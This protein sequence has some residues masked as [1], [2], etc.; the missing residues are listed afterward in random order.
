MTFP[1]TNP[2]PR[3]G[4]T[5]GEFGLLAWLENTC[6]VLPLKVIDVTFDVAGDLA[7]VG[8]DQVFHQTARKPLDILYTFPLPDGAAVF[9]CEVIINDRVLQARVEK[10]ERAREIA[11]AM[12]QAGHRTDFVE[13]DRKNLFTLSLGNVQPDDLIV[14]RLAWFQVLD[15]LQNSKSLRIPFTPGVRYIPGKPLLRSNQ[16]KGTLDD[17]DQVPEASRVLPPRINELHPDAAVISLRGMLDARFL[18]KQSLSSA[19]H[20]VLVRDQDDGV[21]VSLS[22]EGHVPDRDFVLRWE[23]RP[24]EALEFRSIRC[25]DEQHQYAVLGLDAA[26]SA[27]VKSHENNDYYFLVDRSRSMAGRKWACTAQALQAFIAELDEAERVW[28]TLFA[29]AHQEYAEAPLRVSELREDPAFPALVDLGVGGGTE[30]LPAL[31][32]VLLQIATHSTEKKAVVILI[33]DGQ[34]GNEQEIARVLSH[35]PDLRL[36]TFGIDTAV[37]G[38]FLTGLASEHRGTC[39]L[40]KP[41]DDIR[42]AITRLGT[43]L[44]RPLLTDLILPN[45]W[46]STAGRLPDIHAGEHATVALRGPLGATSLE[47]TGTVEDKLLRAYS[48]SLK[49]GARSA[50]RLLW[51]RETIDHLLLAKKYDEAIEIAM[52]HNIICPGTAFIAY[53][54][55]QKV[56]F[57]AQEIYQPAQDTAQQRMAACAMPPPSMD[58]NIALA[59]ATRRLPRVRNQFASPPMP[60]D[61]PPTAKKFPVRTQVLLDLWKSNALQVPLLSGPTGL[62]LIDLLCSWARQD[63]TARIE[64]L[65]ALVTGLR[66]TSIPLVVL[67]QFIRDHV[68]NSAEARQLIAALDML[69]RGRA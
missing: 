3:S 48:F 31:K 57:A 53:D 4:A 23:D 7:E 1:H 61:P 32:H 6:L 55:Q 2:S 21:F 15:C 13:M 44:R 58:L 8:L 47:I 33:T 60:P 26:P 27:T 49:P 25:T 38:A 40:M 24:V 68:L 34:V 22:S 19:T 62:E 67:R 66:E 17:T 18:A 35:S 36:H 45:G 12:R 30:L 28:I 46:E 20:P 56:A 50:P 69:E 64:L 39:V 63:L 54:T 16:G 51:A 37:N 29:S 41:D 65:H 9:K 59:P 10:Q 52:R 43:R 11:L 5:P 42:G 14:V